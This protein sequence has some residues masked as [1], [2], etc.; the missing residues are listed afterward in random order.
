MP[1]VFSSSW[2]TFISREKP[3]AFQLKFGSPRSAPTA[4]K[5]PCIIL[6]QLLMQFS[7]LNQHTILTTIRN[8]KCIIHFKNFYSETYQFL[9]CQ[10]IF[11]KDEIRIFKC[12]LQTLKSFQGYYYNSKPLA[13]LLNTIPFVPPATLPHTACPVEHKS[14]TPQQEQ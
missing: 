5:Y 9:C 13:S 7:F 2:M 4:P 3:D 14:S 10:L 8:R 6:K 1:L 11:E 12:G